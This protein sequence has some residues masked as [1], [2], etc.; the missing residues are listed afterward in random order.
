MKKG[1]CLILVPLLTLGSFSFAEE[2]KTGG[3]ETILAGM[4][5]RDKVAQMMIASFRTWQEGMAEG[6]AWSAVFWCNHDQPRAVSRISAAFCCLRKILP[7]R[8][9]PSGWFRRCGR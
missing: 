2:T 6:G 7:A 9:R 4:S 5:L 8:S 1:L 3:I